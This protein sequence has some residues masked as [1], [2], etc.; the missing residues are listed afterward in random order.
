[1]GVPVTNLDQSFM[2]SKVIGPHTLKFDVHFHMI[3]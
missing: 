2:V 1:M 3:R